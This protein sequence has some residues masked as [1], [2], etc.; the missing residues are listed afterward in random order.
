MQL[1]QGQTISGANPSD[2]RCI[3]YS[4]ES[5]VACLL[6]ES[7][8]LFETDR[9]SSHSAMSITSSINEFIFCFSQENKAVH[10]QELADR[11][12]EL[13]VRLPSC[14]GCFYALVFHV[15]EAECRS[16]ST[17]FH[18]VTSSVYF[19]SRQ[20]CGDDVIAF[21]KLGFPSTVKN[22]FKTLRFRD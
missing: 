13:E 7:T 14:Q 3:Q 16:T 18:R 4:S 8:G 15:T 6:V 17:T 19:H 22:V 20:H 10:I 11:I 9:F 1:I 12:T 5:R 21:G 2:P